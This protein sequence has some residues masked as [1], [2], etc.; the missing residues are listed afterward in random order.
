MSNKE[1]VQKV[2]G[3]GGGGA[4]DEKHLRVEST[5][6]GVMNFEIDF[7]WQRGIVPIF[8][9]VRRMHTACQTL[10]PNQRLCL[11]LWVFRQKAV[12][13]VFAFGCLD[14]KQSLLSSPFGCSDKKQ[15]PLSSSLGVQT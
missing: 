9:I 2:G 5:I 15:S 11:R 4:D 8:G 3:R 7:S 1:Q 13:V 12:D 10:S 6:N 14:V